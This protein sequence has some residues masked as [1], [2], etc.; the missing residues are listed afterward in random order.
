MASMPGTVDGNSVAQ[1]AHAMEKAFPNLNFWQ[2]T[3]NRSAGHNVATTES[4]QHLP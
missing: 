1:F 4:P 2:Q 3:A